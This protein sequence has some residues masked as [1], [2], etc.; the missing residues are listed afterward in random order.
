MIQNVSVADIS[1]EATKTAIENVIKDMVEKRRDEILMYVSELLTRDEILQIVKD[2]VEY[3]D[4]LRD[5]I[6]EMVSDKVVK[7]VSDYFSEH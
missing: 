5:T 1:Y 3:D 2:I 6:R 7:I 4:I